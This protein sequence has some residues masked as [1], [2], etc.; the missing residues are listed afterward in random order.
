MNLLREPTNIYLFSCRKIGTG[1]NSNKF[2]SNILNTRHAFLTVT[3]IL[4]PFFLFLLRRN[5]YQQILQWIFLFAVLIIATIN[6][7]Y[8]WNIGSKG[9]VN[10]PVIHSTYFLTPNNVSFPVRAQIYV[11]R[12]V[13]G[14]CQYNAAYD[15][16]TETIKTGDVI[17]IDAFRLK[18]MIGL[19]Y[20]CMTI[21]YTYRQMVRETIQL[22]SDGIN[23]IRSNPAATE[24]SIL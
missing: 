6:P 12:F 3:N 10:G 21:F 1:Q 11:G 2:L 13:N 17:D 8:A 14:A 19:G 23:Y 18:S 22:N 5:K 4:S 24:V 7:S 9:R 20:S 16:G 15:L